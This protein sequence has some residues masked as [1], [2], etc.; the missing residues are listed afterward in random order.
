MLVRAFGA[1]KKAI[2]Y[3]ADLTEIQN[4]VDVTFGSAASKIDEF[5]KTSIKDFGINAEDIN[6][7]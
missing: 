4:V 3:A 2:N 5:T 6:T 1:L 7:E